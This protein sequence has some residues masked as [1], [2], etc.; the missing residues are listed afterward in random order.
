MRVPAIAASRS[1]RSWVGGWVANMASILSAPSGLTMNIEAEAGLRSAGRFT[2]RPAALAILANAEAS[3]SGWPEISAPM[4][5]ASYSR[6][7]EIAICT[8]PAANGAT[9]IA[10]SR[11]IPPPRPSRP[12]AN[13]IMLPSMA[14]APASVAV[15]VMVSVSRWRIWASSWAITPASSSRSRVRKSPCE[16]ATAAFCGLRPV[17]KAFGCS[18]GRM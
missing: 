7:R 11:P 14:M 17:A 12:P 1:M 18:A 4:R 13:I 6:V 2:V 15:T 9:N 5:S 10:T 3:L 8:S 16:T